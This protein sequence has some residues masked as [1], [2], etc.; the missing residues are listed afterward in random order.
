[1]L[2][3][4]TRE[5]KGTGVTCTDWDLMFAFTIQ[6]LT[7]LSLDIKLTISLGHKPIV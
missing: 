3:G 7:F 4:Q 1:M 6:A 2:R 5:Q